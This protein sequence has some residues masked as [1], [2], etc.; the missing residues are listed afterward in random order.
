MKGL[1]RISWAG[2]IMVM[3]LSV[4]PAQGQTYNLMPQPAQL[5]PG[6][7]RLAID[8]GFRVALEGYQEPRLEAAAVRLIRRLSRQTGIP[9]S[10]V[11][12]TDPSKATLVLHCDHAGEQVQS[13]KEDESY[14]L[15]VGSRQARLTAS[16]PVGV[17]RGIETFLQLATLDAQ[18]FGAPAVRIEDHPRFP[19][20]GL[21]IDVARHWMPEEVLKRNL[22]AMA[23]VKLNVLHFHL[24]DDQGF[25]VDSKEHPKLPEMGSDG[26]YYTQ[27]QIIDL[28]AYARDRGIRVVPEIEMPGHCTSWFVGYP[29][30]ASGPGPFQIE[31]HWGIF[32]P[33]LDPTRP[34]IY[35]FL[36]GLIGEIAALFPDEYLHVGGDE[37]NG[38]QWDRNPQI[39][40]FKKAHGLKNNADLQ[41]YFE[42]QLLPIVQKH[43]KKMIGWDEIFRPDLPKDVVVHSW[44]GPESLAQTARLGYMSIL[45]NGYYLDFALPPAA[46]YR[47][48]PLGGAARSL[49]PEQAS[50]VLGGEACMW[51]ELVTPENVDS[52]IWPSTAAIAERFWSPQDVQDV[53]SMYRRLEVVSRELDWEGVTHDSSY[54]LMLARLAGVHSPEELATLA[55]VVEPIKEYAREGAREYTSFTPLNRLVDAT[56]P[57]SVKARLFSEL[58]DHLGANKDAVRKQLLAWR[59]SREALLPLLQQS[60]LLTETLPLAEDLSAVAQAGLQALDYLD[61]GKSAPPSWVKDQLTVLGLAAKPRAEVMLMIVPPVRKLV[62]AAG[63]GSR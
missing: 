14:Q 7:G 19:W 5:V 40:A 37:V 43:G 60:A 23:A 44:R 16:T 41:L 24:T 21:M 38:K 55:D 30:L 62:E 1:I 3:L 42:Q 26:H 54:P 46:Y 35:T 2:C 56:R 27:A 61:A 8:A 6:S 15:E 52:R 9:L 51:S 29:E 11:L 48:D 32:D 63:K 59:D 33:A 4:H 18:G 12:E 25:R 28:I 49:T 13:I 17:L 45:S 10:Y 22:N 34:E 58:V 39:Q 57:E 20:R 36:D 50:R 31:R 53:G 47:V